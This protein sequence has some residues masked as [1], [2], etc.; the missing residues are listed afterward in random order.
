[1]VRLLSGVST[2]YFI[3][4]DMIIHVYCR[5]I[6]FKG[7]L[8]GCER[9]SGELILVKCFFFFLKLIVRSY[10]FIYFLN[11]T[12]LIFLLCCW[13]VVSLMHCLPMDHVIGEGFGR[14]IDSIM[15]ISHKA[16]IAFNFIVGISSIIP[17]LHTSIWLNTIKV[18]Q[19]FPRTPTVSASF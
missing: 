16:I 18:A 8:H 6:N 11:I 3:V 19:P 7:C 15:S 14:I 17:K 2:G 12:C 13:H 4:S 1:M 10:L 9:G 5:S